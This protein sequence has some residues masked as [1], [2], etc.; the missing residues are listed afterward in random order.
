MTEMKLNYILVPGL[1]IK[2]SMGIQRGK[3]DQIDA[4]KIA[5]YAYRR[6]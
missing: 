4:K 1:E 2:R 6:R 5:Q 3:N